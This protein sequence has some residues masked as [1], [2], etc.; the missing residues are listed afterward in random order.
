MT[1]IS[2][3]QKAKNANHQQAKSFSIDLNVLKGKPDWTK[4]NTSEWYIPVVAD[5]I[6]Y[7]IPYLITLYET[8]N[9]DKTG[10]E[11]NH[12]ITDKKLA[13]I[14]ERYGV[15]GTTLDIEG[16]KQFVSRLRGTLGSRHNSNS[17]PNISDAYSRMVKLEEWLY[18]TYPSAKK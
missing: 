14:E 13:Y 18:K 6:D 9:F 2:T 1:T 10:T 11:T 8:A 16:F 3:V 12:N 17:D 15:V 7:A 5:G 4:S